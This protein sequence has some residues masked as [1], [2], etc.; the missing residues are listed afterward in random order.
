VDALLANYN[1]STNPAEQTFQQFTIRVIE[2]ELQDTSIR[3]K[4]RRGVAFNN[5]GIKVVESELTFATDTQV[6][7]EE[8]K[9]KL[10]TNK[11]ALPELSLISTSELTS[12]LRSL[13]FLEEGDISLNDFSTDIGVDV[14]LGDFVNDLRGGKALRRRTRRRMDQAGRAVESQVKAEQERANIS[15]QNTI[16]AKKQTME[17]LEESA[18][19]TPVTRPPARGETFIPPTP[20]TGSTT[21]IRGPRR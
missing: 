21:I 17:P 19:E 1:K 13:S 4:R 6:I 18:T 10:I 5:Q 2:E 8:T 12:V 7:I 3:N 15:I 9:I 11:F 20:I 16:K 14:G